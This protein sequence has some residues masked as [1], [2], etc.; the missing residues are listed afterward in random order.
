VETQ[1]S[2][3]P[4]S[5]RLRNGSLQLAFPSAALH[6]TVFSINGKYIAGVEL[7]GKASPCR[8]EGMEKAVYIIRYQERGRE[9]A[10]KSEM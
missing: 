7:K 2:T 3:L 5:A 8:I 6:A 9:I 1:R 4:Y 10:V